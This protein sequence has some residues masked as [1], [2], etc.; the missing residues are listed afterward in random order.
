MNTNKHRCDSEPKRPI[1]KSQ[2]Y[3]WTLEWQS[4]EREAQAD[5]EQGRVQEYVSV[6]ELLKDLRRET[7]LGKE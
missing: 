7:P 3:F 6:G 5:I 1:D 4:A 2:A